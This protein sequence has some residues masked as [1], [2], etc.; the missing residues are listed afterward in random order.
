MR[1]GLAGFDLSDPTDR[2]VARHLG[3]ALR[4]RG[5]RTAVFGPGRPSPR[6]DVDVWHLHLFGR[7]VRP[8]V[9]ALEGRR[10]R[11]ATT[12][13]LVLSDYLRFAGGRSTLARLARLGPVACVSR[14][15]RREAVRLVPALEGRLRL[16]RAYG[17]SLPPR[18]TGRSSAPVPVVL[19]AARL[20]PYKGIDVLLMA[21]ARLL[22]DGVSARLVLAGRDK[23]DG[24]LAAF[25]RRLGLGGSVRFV[26]ELTPARLAGALKD[27]DVFVLPSRREN[28]PIALLEAMAAGKPSVASRA[29]GIPELTGR[30]GALL[31]APGD[32]AALARALGRLLSDPA[33]RRRLG[34]SARGRAA[35]FTWD[36]A[37]AESEALY[38]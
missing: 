30:D 34:A 6:A 2:A 12:L 3:A 7:D 28:F 5:L 32:P 1:V 16:I 11:V 23:T 19:C 17:P 9:S 26:G 38:R 29:G 15:Q 13:H 33:L 25:S 22:D 4:R 35:P 21:F 31:V 27:A 36:R 14:S 37:A 10:A 24:A 8:L 18:R 20:A